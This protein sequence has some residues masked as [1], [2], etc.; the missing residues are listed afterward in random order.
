MSASVRDK[1]KNQDVVAQ[2]LQDTIE[3]KMMN[4]LVPN[5]DRIDVGGQNGG[6]PI[7]SWPWLAPD[8]EQDE[9]VDEVDEEEEVE[10]DEESQ[11]PPDWT[12]LINNFAKQE[13]GPMLQNSFVSN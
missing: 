12:G 5:H 3:D 8:D 6:Q 9:A 1:M 2:K 13:Q 7:Q 11:T 4:P 10:V